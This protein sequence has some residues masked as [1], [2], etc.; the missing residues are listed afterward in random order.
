LAQRN[1]EVVTKMEHEANAVRTV[2]ERLADAIAAGVGSW[3][4][5][6]IQTGLY[7]GYVILNVIGWVHHW[8]PYPFVLLNLFLSFQAAYTGP[9][10]MM[11]QNRQ[12]KLADRRNRLDLQ[13]N[14]L[15]ERESTEILRLLQRLCEKQGID[16]DREACASLQKDTEPAEMIREIDAADRRREAEAKEEARTLTH[17][18]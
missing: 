3:T 16:I 9:I 15:A 10:L 4:F 7:I 2:G 11:S 17:R 12:A 18:K 1:I 8:D 6:L 14:L 13:V 5:L